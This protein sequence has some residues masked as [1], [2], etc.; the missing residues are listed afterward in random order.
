MSIIGRVVWAFYAIFRAPRSG[1][2]GCLSGSGT[3][4]ALTATNLAS[5]D[6]TT[7]I[8]PTELKM[9]REERCLSIQFSDGLKAILSY[10][11]LRVH[12]PSAEVRGHSPSQAVLQTGKEHVLITDIQTVGNYAVQMTYDDGHSSGVYTWE[13]LHE[14]SIHRDELWQTYLETLEAEGASR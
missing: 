3:P 11:F 8:H 2:P 12:S 14:L 5:I 4:Y 9:N 7:D 10:E 1:P 6:M 13:Y